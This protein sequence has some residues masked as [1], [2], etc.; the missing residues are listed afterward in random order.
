MR[1]VI[2]LFAILMLV[3]QSYATRIAKWTLPGLT[4]RADVIV[5]AKLTVNGGMTNAV[6]L[7]ALKGSPG[8]NIVVDSFAVQ[9]EDM[10]FTNGET[11]I[12]FLRRENHGSRMFFSF[13]RQGKWP[14]TVGSVPYDDVHVVSL[15]RVEKAVETFLELD[16]T[17]NGDDQIAKLRALLSS[18]DGFDQSCALE[19]LNRCR[20]RR[21]RDAVR[22][23]VDDVRRTSQDR[24][25]QNYCDSVNKTNFIASFF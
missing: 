1:I 2:L 16:Q 19:Y 14:K 20:D 15:Q 24:Y 3:P 17:S 25:I 7:R 8:T 21:V 5:V 11:A 22:F 18:T 6:V 23:N 10:Q 4:E 13:G 12:L 9:R